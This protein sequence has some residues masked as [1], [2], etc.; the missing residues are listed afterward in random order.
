MIE[1][2]DVIRELRGQLEKAAA[3]GAGA[4]I[5]FEVGEVEL[6]VSVALEKERQGSGAVR[7]WVLELGGS[8]KEG[9]VDTQ[10]VKITLQPRVTASGRSPRI[11]GLSQPGER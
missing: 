7:F 8:G 5:Q 2:S 6:E 11:S 1:L 9:H 10:R 3:D 4:A